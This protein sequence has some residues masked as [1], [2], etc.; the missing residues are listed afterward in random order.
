MSTKNP[1]NPDLAA[2]H[3]RI[4]WRTVGL[5][6]LA[7]PI[8]ILLLVVLIFHGCGFMS[9]KYH[10][11]ETSAAPNPTPTTV[12]AEIQ[13]EPHTCGLHS[14]RSLYRAYGLD[15]DRYDLRFRLGVDA[16]AN[17]FDDESTGTLQPDLYRVLDQDGFGVQPLSLDD[18]QSQ[19][20]L[21][22]HLRDEH[23]A[24]ALV[25]RSTYHWVVL[26]N[27]AEEDHLTIID[28]LSAEPYSENTHTFLHDYA[29]SVTLIQPA[30][31]DHSAGLPAT[32]QSGASEMLSTLKRHNQL[33]NE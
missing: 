29:L 12:V 6:A 8:V 3:R 22:D 28:S 20:M 31:P 4:L 23:L 25:Y 16:K 18:P 21:N 5:A 30:A 7:T 33:T 15:P 32:H 24:V 10:S 13:T 9:G 11:A 14:L 19:V 27:G 1:T 2:S 26:D 17:P